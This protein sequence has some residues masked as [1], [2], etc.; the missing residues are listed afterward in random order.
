MPT[1]SEDVTVKAILSA[2]GD[3]LRHRI[4][5]AN[6]E[7]REQGGREMNILAGRGKIADLQT[8]LAGFYGLDL[9]SVHVPEPDAAIKKAP[10]NTVNIEIQK[11]QWAHLQDLGQEWDRLVSSGTPAVS[12]STAVFGAYI[13]SVTN[14]SRGCDDIAFNRGSDIGMTQ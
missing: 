2:K 5:N 12:P 10:P 13:R 7:A 4:A 3:Q 9:C 1:P 6:N 14:R 8:R 11:K